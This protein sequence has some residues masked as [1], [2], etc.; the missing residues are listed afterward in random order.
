MSSGFIQGLFS[1][2]ILF[3]IFINLF[4]FSL[5]GVASVNADD[6]KYAGNYTVISTREQIQRDINIICNRSDSM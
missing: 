5:K 3:N 2:P 6:T 4:L 1:G